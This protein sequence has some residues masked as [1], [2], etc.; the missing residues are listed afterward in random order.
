MRITGQDIYDIA[1]H[2]VHSMSKYMENYMQS[3]NLMS[4]NYYVQSMVAVEM[5]SKYSKYDIQEAFED[6]R[7]QAIV[8]FYEMD[9]DDEDDFRRL[10]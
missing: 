10:H 3:G 7:I 4:F 6:H 2:I 5:Q 9:S 1:E 8:S